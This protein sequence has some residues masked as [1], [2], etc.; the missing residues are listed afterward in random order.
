MCL[1]DDRPAI[2]DDEDFD[3]EAV[4]PNLQSITGLYDKSLYCN[5][6]FLK[7]WR[8]RL[9]SPFLT[10]GN[11]TQFRIDQFDSLQKNCS[12]SMPYT[13]SEATLFVSV[14]GT[15][16]TPTIGGGTTGVGATATCTG[17]VVRPSETPLFC[18]N[19]ADRYNISTG[20]LKIITK[21]SGCQFA[22]AICIP[23]PC[24]TQVIKTYTETCKGLAAQLSNATHPVTIEQFMAWNP[25]LEGSC[26]EITLDQRICTGYASQNLHHHALLI[27]AVLQ[28]GFGYLIRPSSHHR[29]AVRYTIQRPRRLYQHNQGPSRTAVAITPWWTV[30]P[31]IL[32]VSCMASLLQRYA[33]S[34]PISMT[35]VPTFGSSPQCA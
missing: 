34:I 10:P 17:R 1:V 21:S 9:I 29:A 7:I 16:P 25:Y 33:N 28:A 22:G 13:T 15:T 2:C 19:L 35:G 24:N 3:A 23:L 14:A 12:T 5:E 4:D 8:Q 11:W 27:S 20:E 32:Y 18:N 31:A 26:D 30:T 6:C